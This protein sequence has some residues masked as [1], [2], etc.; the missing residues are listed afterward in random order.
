MRGF[1]IVAVLVA[2]ATAVGCGAGGETAASGAANDEAA[3]AYVSDLDGLCLSSAAEQREIAVDP[4]LGATE[5]ERAVEANEARAKALPLFDELEPPPALAADHKRYVAALTEL[6][7][8]NERVT[9]AIDS[10][11]RARRTR[12]AARI[13]R[14]TEQFLKLGADLG[15]REC[16]DDATTSEIAYMTEAIDAVETTNDP[17]QC[18]ERFTKDYLKLTHAGSLADCEA[19]QEDYEPADS[20]EAADLSTVGPFGFAEVTPI[21]G[22]SDGQTVRYLLHL[23]RGTWKVDAILPSR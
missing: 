17:A 12:A 10:R 4:E 13:A 16:T 14:R 5:S 21:G 2:A 7:V 15:A 1:G 23:D 6:A 11:D 9:N 19:F 3:A 8:L 22:P 18:K 20:F